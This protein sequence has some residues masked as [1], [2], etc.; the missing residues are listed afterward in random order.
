MEPR[1]IATCLIGLLLTPTL[2]AA[3]VADQLPSGANAVAVIKL[4]PIL[5]SA[6]AKEKNWRAEMSKTPYERPLSVPVNSTRI[7]TAAKLNLMTL[8]P[9]WQASLIESPTPLNV[10]RMAAKRSGYV[11]IVEGKALVYSPGGACFGQKSDGVIAALWPADRQATARWIRDKTHAVGL[12]PAL[13]E[14]VKSDAQFAVSIDLADAY[15][16]AGLFQSIRNGG[17]PSLDKYDG[18]VGKLTKSL[19]SIQRLGITA[20]FGTSIQGNVVATF[21]SDVSAV[22]PYAKALVMDAIAEAG[23]DPTQFGS[24]SF[25]AAG[26]EIKGTG[27]ISDDLLN[28]L[29]SPFT[30]PAMPEPAGGEAT[31]AEDTK[32]KQAQASVAYYKAVGKIIDNLNFK[33]ASLQQTGAYLRNQALMID[34]MPILNVDPVLQDFASRVSTALTGSAQACVSGQNQ[35][36]AASEAIASPTGATNNNDYYDDS[37]DSAQARADFR[38]AQRQRRQAG[39][40]QRTKTLDAVTAHLAEATAPR[41]EVRKQMTQ[42]Y[43][44]EF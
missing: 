39:A 9:H 17:F 4:P 8:E 43:G 20:R 33:Q 5:D 25:S 31:S 26:N 27:P 21:G 12:S 28:Y 37:D 32:K 29:T 35:A 30:P 10:E 3:D 42:K 38:N 7:V 44:V 24:W 36:I 34:R 14:A 2:Y 11:D 6:F 23:G 41:N 18:D 13:D 15:S 40:D 1:S 16:P 19:A 22:G